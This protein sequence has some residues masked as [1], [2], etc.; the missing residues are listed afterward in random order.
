MDNTE[1]DKARERQRAWRRQFR[2]IDYYPCSD[3]ADGLRA[4]RRSQTG[5]TYSDLINEAVVEW[6]ERNK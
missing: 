2:R 4:L 3:A 1:N 6:C 5:W